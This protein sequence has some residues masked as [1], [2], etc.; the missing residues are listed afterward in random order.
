VLVLGSAARSESLL[1]LDQDNALIHA[2]EPA[3]DA[4]FAEFGAALAELLDEAGLP[5]CKGG[6][7]ASNAQWRGTQSEW[8]ER[9][10]GWLSRA[11]SRDL[12]NVDIFFDLV[13]VA[14]EAQLAR[15]LHAEA[16]AAAA[17]SRTFLALLAESVGSM[18]PSLGLFGTLKTEG[19]R[20]DLKRG[21]LLPL[22]G[23]ARALALRVGSLEL[24]TPGR[25][26][27]AAAES[28]IVGADARRLVEAHTELLA[29]VLRQQLG[30]LAAGVRPSARVAGQPLGPEGRRRLAADLRRLEEMLQGLQ[31]TIAG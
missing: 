12:L 11:R 18:S 24:S 15:E 27:A 5:R 10:A 28:R 13:P 26:Q 14:G 21:A 9:V 8:R 2:G 6:V 16:V 20:I 31:R 23:L 1:S 19:G 22:V 7:M 3:D 25:L 17:R 29:L 30:D 4:W